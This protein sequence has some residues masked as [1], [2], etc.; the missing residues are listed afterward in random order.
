MAGKLTKADGQDVS[1]S[2]SKIQRKLSS[3]H[4][5]SE[6]LILILSSGGEEVYDDGKS[7]GIGIGH[8]NQE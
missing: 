8:C 5:A 3:L 6:G 7:G 4:A 1:K 2:K